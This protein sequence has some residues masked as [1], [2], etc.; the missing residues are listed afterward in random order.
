[1]TYTRSFFHCD[2]LPL[3]FHLLFN[4]LQVLST[5]SSWQNKQRKQTWLNLDMVWLLVLS[6]GDWRCIMQPFANQK[7]HWRSCWPKAS[8]LTE[9]T[10]TAWRPWCMPAWQTGRRMSRGLT[11]DTDNHG[12]AGAAHTVS[13]KYCKVRRDDGIQMHT[14]DFKGLNGN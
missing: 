13:S 6:R 5:T 4:V 3:V 8:R 11:M 1:M 10:A 2:A 14:R 12:H 9:S 7:S